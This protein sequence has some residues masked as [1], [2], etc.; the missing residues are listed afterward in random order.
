M[1]EIDITNEIENRHCP[2]C[3]DR[4]RKGSPLH[5]CNEKKLKALELKDNISETNE[6]SGEY[7]EEERTYDDKLRESE[8]HY[9]N[10]TY[11][12]IGE[13]E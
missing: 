13:D 7:L 9:D 2:I 5:R 10:S 4:V 1:D 8:K 6:N 3:G 12:D 11:Y